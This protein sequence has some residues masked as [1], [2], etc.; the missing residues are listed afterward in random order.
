V[1]RI[2]D[3]FVLQQEDNMVDIDTLV[4]VDRVEEEDNNTEELDTHKVVVGVVGNKLVVDNTLVEVVRLLCNNK[5]RILFEQVVHILYMQFVDNFLF[6]HYQH[7][8][9]F[10]S[11]YKM[12]WHWQNM[13]LFVRIYYKKLS[14]SQSVLC[15]VMMF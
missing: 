2:V 15:H 13:I 11:Y 6:P 8:D 1:V 10:E 9:Y 3:I 12:H 4:V 14:Q 5:D 7:F